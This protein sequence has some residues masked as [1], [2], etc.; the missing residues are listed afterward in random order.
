MEFSYRISEGDHLAAWNLVLKNNFRSKDSRTI[1][2]WVV[3]NV[4]LLAVWFVVNRRPIPVQELE[5]SSSYASS[6][7]LLTSILSVIGLVTLGRI[8]YRLKKR[9][10]ILR[11]VFQKNPLMQGEFTVNITADGVSYQ[12]TA[13]SSS[14]SRWEIYESWSE[15]NDLIVLNLRNESFFILSVKAL[16]AA[17]MRDLQEILS[18]ALPQK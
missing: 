5:S 10:A 1:A 18:A 8:L 6:Y 16:S 3:I 9:P 2:I 15:D 11:E 12:N 13:G 17:R 7:S 4:V 14:S